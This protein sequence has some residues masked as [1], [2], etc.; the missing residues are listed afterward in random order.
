VLSPAREML[1]PECDVRFRGRTLEGVVEISGTSTS[2]AS[3]RAHAKY[4]TY[5]TELL[6]RPIASKDKGYSNGC[7]MKRQ[8][9]S[10]N[11]KDML[12]A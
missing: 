11:G 5:N 4:N 1:Y 7:D 12:I 10:S 8:A 2:R 6:P 9:L 3:Q